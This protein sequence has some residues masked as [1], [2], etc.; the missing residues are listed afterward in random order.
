MFHKIISVI[1]VSVFILTNAAYGDSLRVPIG[2]WKGREK[3][4]LKE[5]NKT[6]KDSYKR[7]EGLPELAFIDKTIATIDNYEV[8]I[9]TLPG[10]DKNR[11]R[12]KRFIVVYDTSTKEVPKWFNNI[13]VTYEEPRVRCYNENHLLEI[14]I[15]KDAVGDNLL[16]L[17]T[18]TSEKVF[19]DNEANVLLNNRSDYYIIRHYM[20]GRRISD[21]LKVYD[22]KNHKMLK[23]V[24]GR[25]CQLI[26]G[27]FL[28][29][30]SESYWN[31]YSRITI[32]DLTTTEKVLSFSCGEVMSWKF[33]EGN[34]IICTKKDTKGVN[35][36]E[37]Y[38][39]LTGES[40]GTTYIHNA[41][42][43]FV[44]KTIRYQ[45]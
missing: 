33:Q 45:L 24:T 30:N 7:P 39:L 31:I 29:V 3:D 38:S 17:N 27:R 43:T 41:I 19:Y 13:L 40:L 5:N 25:S 12:Y 6:A 1:V 22:I 26:E 20:S 34:K 16:V 42:E 21:E 2:A 4:I 18:K 11:K 23:T 8:V 35:Y 15:Q 9:Y 14:H 28:S 37:T 36:K 44:V 10:N 32:Y